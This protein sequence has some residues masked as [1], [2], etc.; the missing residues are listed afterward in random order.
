MSLHDFTRHGKAA[1]IVGGQFGSEAKGMAAAV[2]AREDYLLNKPGRQFIATTNAGAQAGHTTILEDGSKFIC[3][4]LPT[5]GVLLKHSTIYLNAGSIIDLDL[6]DRE[7]TDV[8]NALGRDPNDL[9]RRI[10]IHPNAAIISSNN[11]LQEVGDG[12]GSGMTT[13]LGSTMKGVGAALASKIMRRPLTIAGEVIAVDHNSV[14]LYGM[15]YKVGVIN[16]N[17][18]LSKG[19]SVTVEIPQGT[20]LS[21][22]ASL[23]YP[24]CTS[25]DCWVGQGLA[26]ASIHPSFLGNVLMVQRAFPIRVGHV[27]D[28]HTGERIGNSGPF[29]PDS[30]EMEWTEFPG[31]EP[32][33]TTVTQRVRRIASWSKM[34]YAEALALNRPTHVMTTFINYLKDDRYLRIL[35]GRMRLEHSRLNINPHTLWSWGPRTDQWSDDTDDATAEMQVSKQGL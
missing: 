19:G 20:G 7:I 33:R 35:N 18:S 21:L 4:H 26:D 24:H 6:L 22:N 2:V 15:L 10:I 28:P 9:A 14:S 25:R 13:H 16:L 11:K 1:V 17:E 23:F 34:Q 3:Y 29:Y 12:R 8:S 32:E 31:I 5:I 30:T 27:Y